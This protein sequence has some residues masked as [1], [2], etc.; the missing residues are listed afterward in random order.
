[1]KNKQVG[2]LILGMAIVFLFIVMSFNNALET[3]VRTSCTHG[4]SCPMEITLKTQ[5]A[6]SYSLIGVLTLVGGFIAFFMKEDEIV[7]HH[8]HK[9]EMSS[10]DKKRKLEHLDEAER[11]IMNIVLREDGSVYQSDLIKETKKSKVQVSR[12][13]DKLEGKGLI[14]RKRRGMTNVIVLK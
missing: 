11:M 5:K 2:L 9:K 10:E 6:V 4:V 3:I 8:H 7:H 14:E 12:V 13:L 1:M